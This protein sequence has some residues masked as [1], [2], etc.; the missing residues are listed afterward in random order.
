MYLHDGVTA[1][2]CDLPAQDET[3]KRLDAKHKGSREDELRKAATPAHLGPRSDAVH[4]LVEWAT[5]E[6]L[7][8]ASHRR[9]ILA[10]HGPEGT[11]D[12]AHDDRA[13]HH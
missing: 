2:V 10:L 11:I 6:P 5:K 1:H 8:D 4:D 7:L 3:V 13:G 9:A 12:Q